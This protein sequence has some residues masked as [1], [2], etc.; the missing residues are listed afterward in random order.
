[1][2]DNL[3]ER[4]YLE[5]YAGLEG[6]DL[7]EAVIRDYRG[8]VALVSSFG[9]ESAALLHMV[10]AI[11]PATPVIFLDTGKLFPET[12]AYRDTLTG[13]LGLRD[14]R[15]ISPD[16]GDLAM[17]DPDG[18]LHQRD[19]DACCH[20]RKTIPLERALRGFDA[21]L[22]G[23]KRFH[24]G[25]RAGLDFVKIADGRLKVEPLAAFSAF[26]LKAYLADHDLAAHPLVAQGYRSIGCMPCTARGGSDEDPRAGRW[27]GTDKTECG[28]H[29][30]A[31]GRPIRITRP[32]PLAV[33]SVC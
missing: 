13:L 17:N 31:N 27:T 24:G 22:S 19:T 32:E 11:D 25:E 28:I 14:V 9:A 7:T 8:R 29:W 20:V 33:A 10:A 1:M 26:D 12:L 5:N 30:T 4:H 2:L 18:S 3:G 23:R 21:V 6:A 16:A 15:T